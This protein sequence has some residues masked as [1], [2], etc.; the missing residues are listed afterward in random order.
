MYY[1]CIHYYISIYFQK[2]YLDYYIIKSDAGRG[3]RSL[4][5]QSFKCI[6]RRCYY[7]FKVDSS[8]GS[9]LVLPT[10]FYKL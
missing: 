5:E 4:G 8:K 9:R 6:A 10:T 3:P 1:I 2:K 7:V